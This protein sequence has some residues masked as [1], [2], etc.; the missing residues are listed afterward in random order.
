[1]KA[2][3]REA[4]Y[5]EDGYGA[6]HKEAKRVPDAIHGFAVVP[7]CNRNVTLYETFPA[8]AAFHWKNVTC[9]RCLRSK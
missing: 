3:L 9:K 4:R 2:V 1:M 7:K 6:V 8:Q 5:F